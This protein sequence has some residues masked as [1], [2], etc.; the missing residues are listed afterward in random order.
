M[1]YE[2]SEIMFA[3]ALLV[4]PKPEEYSSVSKLKTLMKKC[5]S[6]V[7]KNPKGVQ[8]GNKQISDGFLETMDEN[9]PDK[10]TDLAAGISAANAVRK[11]MGV[12]AS[13]NVTSYMTGNVW[14]KDVE[15][16]KV[17]AYGFAD[18]NSADV[19]V[20]ADNK[21][22]YGF[23]LKKKKKTTD[24]SPTLINKAFD[25]LLI[26]EE[27]DDTKKKLVEIRTEY[28][29]DLVIEAVKKKIILKKDIKNF[30]NLAS[31]NKKELF[32]AKQRDKTQFDRAY[33]DTKGYAMAD[34][35]YLDPNTNDPKSMRAFVNSKLAESKNPLFEAFLKVLNKNSQL[36][37]D[38][39]L[40]I[41]LKVK[42]F[43]EMDAKELKKFKF[44][45]ALVTGV[46][47]VRGDDVFVG[48]SSVVDL[49]T[50]L[51]GL[52][53][54]DKYY[55]NDEYKIAVDKEKSAKSKGAKIFLQL[56][57][58]I[59]VLLDL[60]IRYKGAFTPQPQFQATLS[61]KFIEFLKKECDL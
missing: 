4:Q 59:L 41:I 43:D 29:A 19:M 50:T 57:R 47:Y 21:T 15:K 30:D 10:L 27:F 22:F 11:Y 56:K 1:A 18:Y 24:A 42:L 37:A 20:T 40:N 13:K 51:C 32:E 36:F 7:K 38:S 52:T 16:F 31:N 23:S 12:S 45:F 58:G 44:D 39:L 54:L 6:E 3:A 5:K 34:K 14:P 53:R 25:S 28:F 17:S 60:E 26:G 48:T 9:K 55:K 8:F 35:G 2:A 46:G 49:K 61:Q 33:I